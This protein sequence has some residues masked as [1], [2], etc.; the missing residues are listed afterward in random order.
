[1]AG[2]WRQVRKAHLLPYKSL[3]HTQPCTRTA[4]AIETRGMP[5]ETVIGRIRGLIEKDKDLPAVT[6]KMAPA[7]GETRQERNDYIW[8]KYSEYTNKRTSR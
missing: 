2:T 6:G 4:K 5:A 8:Q 7:A 3:W 1:M